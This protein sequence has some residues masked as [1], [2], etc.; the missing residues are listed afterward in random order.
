[1]MKISNIYFFLAY[2]V[3]LPYNHQMDVLT[4]AKYDARAKILKA[5]AHPTRLFIIDELIN[6]KKCVCELT[7]MI[8]AD[9]STV[10]K[11]LSVLKNAGIVQDKKMGTKIF[12]QLR[13]GCVTNFLGC[14]ESVIKTN[15]EAQLELIK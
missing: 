13:C 2:L 5:M 3:N 9:M 8:G 1:M 11:H 7:K 14:I 4:K 6:G 10:S 15:I 12:Y